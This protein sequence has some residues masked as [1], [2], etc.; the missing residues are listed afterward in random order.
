MKAVLIPGDGIGKEISES[1]LQ[2]TEALRLN[3]DW[4]TYQ[5]GADY[6]LAHGELFE[7]GLLEAIKEYKWALKGPTATP[8]GTGFRSVNVALRQY[9]ETYANVRPV[10]SLEG[11]TSRYEFI[12]LVTIRENTEDLYKGIEYKINDNMANGVK[13]ITRKASEKICR[14]AFEYAQKHNRH[15]VTAVHKANIMK[16]TDGLFLEAYREVAKDYPEIQT[17][18]IIVDNMCMQLVLYPEKYDVLVAPNLYGDI[19]SDLCAGLVGGLGFAPS[20][21][22]GDDYHIYEAAHGSAPDIAG[23]NIANPS[24]L[25]LSFVMM[26]EAL[27]ERNAAQKIKEALNEV[28]KEG[29]KTTPD[30]GGQATTTEF[31]QAIINKIQTGR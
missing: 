3:I 14:Y 29:V 4:V 17:Q 10:K 30:I 11:I 7:P 26:L 8:I 31:T 15:K 23:K 5:A 25:I 22:I 16:L 18:E 9:F 2:I 20:A 6:A 21:N 24:A 28:V 13:L 27:G 1:I 19:I 12:D